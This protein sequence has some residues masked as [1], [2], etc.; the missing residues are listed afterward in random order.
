MDGRAAKEAVYQRLARMFMDTDDFYAA[1][2]VCAT[3][4]ELTA[5]VARQASVRTGSPMR[6]ERC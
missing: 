2:A 5:G 6:R 1:A 3:L 4:M